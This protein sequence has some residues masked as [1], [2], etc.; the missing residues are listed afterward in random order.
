MEELIVKRMTL[1]DIRG[2]WDIEQLS[3]VTPWSLEALEKELDNERA[4]YLVAELAGKVIGYVG[5]WV[6]LEE[7]HI[8]NVAVHPDYRQK[9]IATLLLIALEEEL[10]ELGVESLTLEVRVSNQ[11]AQSLYAQRG[12][13]PLGLRKKYYTDNDEDALIMWKVN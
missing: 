6:I 9:K 4:L 8:T 7:A 12:F 10:R 11:V 5:C 1:Q 3:F 13:R 2:V